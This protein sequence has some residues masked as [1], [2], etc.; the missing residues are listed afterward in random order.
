MQVAR[1]AA[2]RPG[3]GR[4][5]ELA[6][7][8]EPVR[9]HGRGHGVRG[10]GAGQGVVVGVR[11]RLSEHVDDVNGDRGCDVG[12]GQAGVPVM[13]VRELRRRRDRCRRR[14]LSGRACGGIDL[15]RAGHRAVRG[16]NGRGGGADED[17]LTV[18]AEAGNGRIAALRIAEGL[19]HVSEEVGLR[20]AHERRVHRAP[21]LLPFDEVVVAAG[22]LAQAGDVGQ[23]IV[24]RA[25]QGDRGRGAGHGHAVDQ[26]R[27]RRAAIPKLLPILV[28]DG[29][30]A[31]PRDDR[32][33]RSVKQRPEPDLVEQK[34]QVV[35]VERKRARR[36]GH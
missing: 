28:E 8:Q 10:I 9:H 29:A 24:G 7:G 1:Y 22:H 19:L 30:D 26:G 14:G 32:R 33:A 20:A 21:G 13:P 17:R 3:D 6:A 34:L 25:E 27:E 2:E 5:V 15:Q 36:R 18:R 12:F 31:V 4:G 35:C 16:A 11:H 23:G